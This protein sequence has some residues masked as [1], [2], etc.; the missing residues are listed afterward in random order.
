MNFEREEKKPAAAEPHP[1]LRLNVEKYYKQI[2]Y[3]HWLVDGIN[4][5]LKGKT[6]YTDAVGFDKRKERAERLVEPTHVLIYWKN[7]L[8]LNET[9]VISLHQPNWEFQKELCGALNELG[10]RGFLC[11]KKREND[12]MARRSP[13]P[14][15]NSS[16]W[17]ALFGGR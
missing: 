6:D 4:I 13:L 1:D 11:H 17:D 3:I 8:G 12:G 10:S 9:F 16:Q 5:E 2:S 14:E 15:R 7:N